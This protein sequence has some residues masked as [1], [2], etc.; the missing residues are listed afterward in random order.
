M[1]QRFADIDF[2]RLT[3][4]DAVAP[5]DYETIFNARRDRFLELWEIVRAENPA[6]PDYDTLVLETDPVAVVLQEAAYRELVLRQHINDSYLAATLPY[7]TGHH[8]DTVAALYAVQ[9]LPGESDERLRCRAQLAP[10]ALSV[11]GTVG[12]YIFHA[13]TVAPELHSVDVRSPRPGVVEVTCSMGGSDPRPSDEVLSRVHVHLVDEDRAPLTDMVTVRPP[14]ITRLQVDAELRI[15]NAPARTAVLAEAR[16]A[17][18]EHMVGIRGVDKPV[19]RSGIVAALHVP[20]V[21][22]V[23]LR[24]PMAD[25]LPVGSKASV[26]VVDAVTLEGID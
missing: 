2:S 20:G 26:V 4:P 13:L 8:L 1:A 11:A 17:L 14:T 19:Y 16:A 6:L 24:E 21:S 9:R 15:N 7:A 5:L 22:S 10:E 18:D 12:G 25:V 3:P 23:V